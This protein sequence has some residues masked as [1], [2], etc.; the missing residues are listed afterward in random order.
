MV[1]HLVPRGVATHVPD[2]KERHARGPFPAVS[3]SLESFLS[4]SR[5][6][7]INRGQLNEP[8][9]FKPPGYSN[10]HMGCSL[11]I[12]SALG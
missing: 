9:E 3:R 10:W 2:I 1:I 5:F 6:W 11:A 4:G 12:S 7:D 8:V